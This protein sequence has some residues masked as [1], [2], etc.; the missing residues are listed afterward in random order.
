MGHRLGPL[1]TC[2]VLANTYQTNDGNTMLK[3]MAVMHPAAK[4]LVDLSAAQDVEAGDGT[5]SVVVIAGSLLGAADRLLAKG[6]LPVAKHSK[7]SL[8]SIRHTSYGHLRILPTSSSRGSG[9][10]SR[11]VTS[12]FSFGSSHPTTSSLHLS[13]LQDR[14]PTFKPTRSHSSRRSTENHRPKDSRQ[15]RSKEHSYCQKSRRHDR[16]LRNDRRPHP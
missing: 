7:T 13:L 3:S 11:H 14:F 12:H 4:M 9:S 5:T 16:R 2:R 10:A 1:A 15:R 8:T 6:V